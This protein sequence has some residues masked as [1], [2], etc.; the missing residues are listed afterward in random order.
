MDGLS[1]VNGMSFRLRA[2]AL[3]L[4][5]RTAGRACVT[6][7]FDSGALRS[8]RRQVYWPGHFCARRHDVT[9]TALTM[10]RIIRLP[11]SGAPTIGR[12]LTCPWFCEE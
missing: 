7:S 4:A 6:A 12:A 3:H 10:E 1:R 9:R 2:G 5:D 8:T 11:V